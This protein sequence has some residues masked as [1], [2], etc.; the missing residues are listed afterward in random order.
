MVI[1]EMVVKQL[2]SRRAGRV[3]VDASA[4][5]SQVV[6]AFDGEVVSIDTDLWQHRRRKDVDELELMRTAIACSEAMHRR[7]RELIAPGIAELEVFTELNAAAV[8]AAGEPLSALLGNDYA[9]G[10]GGGPARG[11]KIAQGWAALCF[12]SG[13]GVSRIF[14]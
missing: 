13:T 12:G 8:K 9:C 4:V 6:M 14:R 5:T 11:G 1:A 10:V 3:G 7:A 2:Q